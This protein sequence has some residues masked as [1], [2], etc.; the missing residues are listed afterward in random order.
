MNAEKW[1]NLFWNLTAI[2]AFGGVIALGIMAW[3]WIEQAIGCGLALFVAA[4]PMLYVRA[5]I[6]EWRA[7]YPPYWN[8]E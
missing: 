5:R 4:L 1:R 2:C 8:H 3:P 7:R 6:I